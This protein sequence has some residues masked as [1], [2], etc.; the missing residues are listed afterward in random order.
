MPGKDSG[1]A[2]G[3]TTRP[4]RPP[5][6][7]T[8]KIKTKRKPAPKTTTTPGLQGD[9]S[10]E[11]AV[12]RKTKTVPKKG[13]SRSSVRPSP[14]LGVDFGGLGSALKGFFS[15]ADAVVREYPQA[16][17]DYIHQEPHG[18]VDP[19]VERKAK[20]AAEF[21]VGENIVKAAGGK[22]FDPK[23]LAIEA[24]LLPAN[25]FAPLKGATVGTTV[26]RGATRAPGVARAAR[27]G[28]GV[29]E[30]KHAVSTPLLKIPGRTFRTGGATAKAA[31][32]RSRT[33]RAVERAFDRTRKYT[34]RVG[35]GKVS[36]VKNEVQKT[37]QL[38]QHRMKHDAKVQML[39]AVRLKKAVGG[40]RNKI[41]YQYVLRSMA[42]GIDPMEA[43]SFHAS[44][45]EEATDELVKSNHLLHVDG[46]MKAA[47]YV[48]RRGDE[49]E[50]LDTAPERLRTAW[51]LFPEASEARESILKNL[52]LLDEDEIA[53]RIQNPGRI[54]KGAKFVAEEEHAMNVIRANPSRHKL[55]ESMMK[56]LPEGAA[57]AQIRVIDE[58]ARA[59]WQAERDE[60]KRLAKN[61]ERKLEKYAEDRAAGVFVDDID[62]AVNQAILEEATAQADALPY[63][64]LYRQLKDS[65]VGI[66]RDVRQRLVRETGRSTLDFRKDV[67]SKAAVLKAVQKALDGF[68]WTPFRAEGQGFDAD[69]MVRAIVDGAPHRFWYEDSAE[70]ILEVAGGDKELADRLA[71]LVAIYSAQRAPKQNMQLAFNAFNEWRQTGV[72][73]N[74]GN[75]HQIKKANDILAGLPWEGR[76]TDRFYANMLEDIDPE[77]YATTFPGGEVTNDIWMA[78]L[79]G[80]KDKKG[81]P[82]DVP[83][84]K[85][86]EAM[87]G[88]V[89]GIADE[90]GWKPKQVQ[91]ATWIAKKSYDEGTDLPTAAYHFGNAIEDEV[92]TVPFE[93]APGSSTA[94]G[95]YERYASLAPEQKRAFTAEKAAAVEQFLRDLGILGKLGDEGVGVYEGQINPGWS[96]FMAA[97][98]AKGAKGA[99]VVTDETR[100]LLDGVAAAIGDALNQDAAVWTKPFFRANLP[101]WR[102]SGVKITLGRAAT[103]EEM[104][105]LNRVLGEDVALVHTPDGVMAL[106][107]SEGATK[108]ATG[109]LNAAFH[110]NVD[111]AL[112][113][114]YPGEKIEGFKFA[115]DGNYIERADYGNHLDGARRGRP[116]LLDGALADLR[117]ASD[118]IDERYLG[119]A[120]GDAG[121]RGAAAAGTRG[122]DDARH[123]REDGGRVDPSGLGEQRRTIARPN[124]GRAIRGGF[125]P[126]SQ[127]F[128]HGVAVPERGADPLGRSI[129]SRVYVSDRTLAPTETWY[130]E[131]AHF[132]QT[133][134]AKAERSLT[135]Y[136]GENKEH[137]VEAWLEYVID[138]YPQRSLPRAV[139]DAF[140]EMSEALM[141]EADNTGGTFVRGMLSDHP[142]AREVAE[143]FDSV[144]W[145]RQ[146]KGGKIRGFEDFAEGKAYTP[147]ELGLPK[148]LRNTFAGQRL[149]A[150]SIAGLFGGKTV[151]RGFVDPSV[152]KQF[153]GYLLENGFY[154]SDVTNASYRSLAKAVKMDSIRKARTFLLQASTEAPVHT[155][156]IPIYVEPAAM[157]KMPPE[158]RQWFAA[159]EDLPEDIRKVGKHVKVSDFDEY[160]DD[161]MFA[162]LANQFFPSQ[163]DGLDSKVVAQQI[164]NGAQDTIPG[165]RWVPAQL[166]YEGDLFAN[167]KA[168]FSRG[169]TWGGLE[170]LGQ[171]VDF[172][173][174]L[175]KL[176]VL[177]LNPA[178]IGMN[179]LGNLSL[180]LLQQGPLA[181]MNLPRAA[182]LSRELSP[183]MATAVDHLMG[184]GI[185]SM[186]TAR[187]KLL[188]PSA[189]LADLTGELVDKIPRRAAF[190][191]EA[192]AAGYR[193]ADEI[194]YLLS[195]ANAA[196]DLYEITTRANDAII[197]YERLS[198]FERNY[199]SR[200]LFIYPWIK[201]ATRYTFRFPLEHPVQA[202]AFA[203]L[204]ERQQALADEQLGERP[205]YAEF[206]LPIGT[207]ER[208]GEEYPLTIN[209]KQLVPFTTPLEFGQAIAGWIA[210]GEQNWQEL[211]DILQ[212]FYPALV[213]SL[214][215][216]DSF[217]NKEVPTGIETFVREAADIPIVGAI[218]RLRQT[219]EE[220]AEGASNRLYPR[221]A[222]DDVLR[223][224]LGSLAP[225]PYN[226]EKGQF[227]AEGGRGKTPEE[228][229]REKKKEIKGFYDPAYEDKVDAALA[230]KVEYEKAK[231]EARKRLGEE[232]LTDVEL[233]DVM[234]VV[235]SKHLP[236]LDVEYVRRNL[237]PM[238]A[239]EIRSELEAALGWN[240]IEAA[241]TAA[242]ERKRVEEAR[243]EGSVVSANG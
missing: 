230:T 49:L 175:M 120:G 150:K 57:K 154:R 137:W 95:L 126:G 132:W 117:R 204:Y 157:R 83:T 134:F 58:Q 140:D 105:A 213:T 173:N 92:A 62:V 220:R 85:E 158:L 125:A 76:K 65:G 98:R 148:S 237:N 102:Q 222:N 11:K 162:D 189:V 79:F 12:I 53:S 91:A 24:A 240:I 99:W 129:T 72:V 8:K 143:V 212:P 1:G 192:W 116:D 198:P 211:I 2:G 13:P 43:A 235:A 7:T 71:Q 32:A 80:L 110:G 144:F 209:P 89:K 210:P 19:E 241:T 142:H 242:N 73:S 69:L 128:I 199:V 183:D 195:D 153:R 203:Y 15:G 171:T 40:L 229:A 118:D 151:A 178:Y 64:W 164:I 18:K 205:W 133:Q 194:T 20:K 202:L 3:T 27:A 47:R 226:P 138:L 30:A 123:L 37:G 152:Q 238:T 163:I 108:N 141:R 82:V 185:S 45:A 172:V 145:Y 112:R 166:L 35:V 224:F 196:D 236:E 44:R 52:G 188:K 208:F 170:A 70:S 159:R 39:P 94:P 77:K 216:W 23:W 103:E 200:I 6:K 186:M 160:G 135:R 109:E 234:L 106:N 5:K 96:V 26:L 182:M 169:D 60:L 121:A 193:S 127:S 97:S 201:G 177:Q 86:Y 227:Y 197:D 218:G 191:H 217:E 149:A 84:P 10:S 21:I 165:V 93:A 168:F 221:N 167:P 176:S 17:V 88:L 74:F 233:A 187:G 219:D 90:L 25:L 184:R 115:R 130:H 38:A 50:L 206:N 161:E 119:G 4:P 111:E 107:L 36:L 46:Y 114:V 190:L 42:M 243:A 225:T 223:T 87:Q 122:V 207:V 75:S 59:A 100:E 156:D 136:L 61:A 48:A 55:L 29:A 66:P 147:F 174:D 101:L 181:L 180:N 63:D 51:R 231:A 113:V 16:I 81:N 9:R 179:L 14:E 239:S 68:D 34:S 139:R 232:D 67:T 104:V 31:S 155:T 124:D 78:R 131:L 41:A 56:Q 228:R 22:D 33:G 214:T 146:L 28:A 54:I 215:G